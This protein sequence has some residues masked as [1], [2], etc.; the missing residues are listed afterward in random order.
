MKTLLI[1]IETA[2][3]K[4]Y[5]WG[6]F[7]QNIATN[8][9]VEAG[10]TL[11]FAAK[12]LDQK[13]VTFSSVHKDGK[14]AMLRLAYNLLDEADVVVHYNGTKFDIPIL[15]QE[16]M[17][18]G[19]APPAPFQEVDVLRTVRKRFRLTSNKLD[20][21]L[22]FL[23]I[24]GKVQHKGMELWHECMEGDKEAWEV[25][26]KYNIGDVTKLEELYKR[27]TGWVFNPPN[28]GLYTHHDGHVCP[29]CGG[30]HLQK[31]GYRYTDTQVYQRYQCNDCGSWSRGRTTILTPAS[32]KQVLKAI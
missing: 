28:H 32:R 14:E 21:V 19:W 4:V 24:P 18:M 25:M 7:N 31:R 23:H 22:K 8:Q 30:K 12:W 17:A 1:D 9:V 15:N 27:L 6:L 29:T 2:P 3:N 13:R 20:Y 16:F 5:T 10:Y 26:K 11:C